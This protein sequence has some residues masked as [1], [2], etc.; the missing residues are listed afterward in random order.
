[1]SE[2][3]FVT[4][5]IVTYNRKE[6]L[7]QCLR[8]NLEQTHTINQIIV[9]DNAS[10]DDTVNFL[11]QEG[12]LAEARIHYC[13]QDEN[14]GGAGGFHVGIQKAMN[15]G[16]TWLWLMDDDAIPEVDA[17]ER[18]L[19]A[20]GN[21]ESPPLLAS[22][23]VN[24]DG[25]TD[26]AHR[27]R[28]PSGPRISAHIPA[29]EY[30]KALIE[31][32]MVSFVGPLL[33]RQHVQACGLPRAE[34][35]IYYDDFDYTYRIKQ[36]GFNVLV[37]P[38]SI[39]R[40][41]DQGRSVR[42]EMMHPSWGWRMYYQVRNRVYWNKSITPSK[43][44]LWQRMLALFAIQWSLVLFRQPAKWTR[45]RLLMRSFTDGWYGR[46]GKTIDPATY[47]E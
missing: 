37:V 1:M 5:V 31:A 4:A 15:M 3:A 12:L 10:S 28:M 25:V 24:A 17:L 21:G 27:A 18:L 36:A 47:H 34:Y 42:E 45:T 29:R 40:H 33:H 20:T 16:A 32:D 19:S 35:F 11:E 22:R 46:L 8:A 26:V 7:V 39:I 9:V 13:R 2:S 23:V 30:A 44:V 43:L 41:L 38:A 14:R 6:L